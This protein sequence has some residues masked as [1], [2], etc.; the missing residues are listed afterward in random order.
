[1]FDRLEGE[2]K[3]FSNDRGYGFVCPIEDG[4]G[5]DEN[6]E[7]FVHF[8]SINISGYKTLSAG[9]RVLFELSET[10]KG[11]QAVNVEVV[12]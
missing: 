10:D 8:S 1:M 5:V 2:V 7:Y 3:W 11:T 12:K 4:G 6:T 9:Q